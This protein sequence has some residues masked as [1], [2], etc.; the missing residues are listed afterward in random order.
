MIVETHD[1]VARSLA[2]A[3]LTGRV[4][5]GA[6]ND[7]DVN[8]LT[9]VLGSFRRVHPGVEV[10]LVVEGGRL[11]DALRRTVEADIERSRPLTASAL[12]ARSPWV[13]LRDRLAAAL[14]SR[15]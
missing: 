7:V 8:R 11:P 15:F 2:N 12:E 6:D 10:N 9:R 3:D 4:T 14:L 5:V 1:R 13:R